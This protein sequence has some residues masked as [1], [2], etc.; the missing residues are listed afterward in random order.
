MKAVRLQV[1]L[2]PPHAV[3]GPRHCHNPIAIILQVATE[4][5]DVKLDCHEI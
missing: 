1:A 4:K 5:D 3:E 2:M